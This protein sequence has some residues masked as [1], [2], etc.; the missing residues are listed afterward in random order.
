MGSLVDDFSQYLFE[1]RPCMRCNAASTECKSVDLDNITK[2]MRATSTAR[3]FSLKN[4]YVI[5]SFSL[6]MPKRRDSSRSAK[7]VNVYVNTRRVADIIDLRDKWDLWKRVQSIRLPEGTRDTVVTFPH[8]VSAANLCIEV[9]ELHSE[10][11]EAP[12]CPRCGNSVPD[13]H[14]ICSHCGENA[15]QCRGCRYIPYEN[16]DAFFCPQCGTCRDCQ[17]EVTLSVYESFVPE[18][19]ES[20]EDLKKATKSLSSHAGSATDALLRLYD[21]KTSSSAYLYP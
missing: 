21:L 4:T 19:V 6:S 3:Y 16:F 20:D 17:F 8:P 11:R 10:R 5:K 18:P 2:Q 1:P 13:R 9:A 7:V 15:Y 14:G 12:K